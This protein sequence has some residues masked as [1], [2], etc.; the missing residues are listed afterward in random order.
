MKL[1]NGTTNG[2]IL[3]AEGEK[4]TVYINDQRIGSFFDF[5]KTR[6]EGYFAFTAYQ[7]SGRG[8]CT[9][10]NTVVWLLK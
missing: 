4:F 9:F 7:E 10:D 6:S 2:Y 5:N 1:E 8:S 3:V